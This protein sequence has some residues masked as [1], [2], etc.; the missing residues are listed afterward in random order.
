MY[1]PDGGSNYVCIR[2]YYYYYFF[3][4]EC[5]RNWMI[6]TSIFIHHLCYASWS[7][8]KSYLMF[9]THFCV[10]YSVYSIT[11][12]C[13]VIC[14]WCCSRVPSK[15]NT[16][17][18]SSST[19]NSGCI[20]HTSKTKVLLPKKILLIHLTCLNL[21]CDN[22][23]PPFILL[24]ITCYNLLITLDK[25][26][27]YFFATHTIVSC[28]TAKFPEFRLPCTPKTLGFYAVCHLLSES[29]LAF[30]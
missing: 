21:F 3:F 16:A 28:L 20:F 24:D 11:S 7:M 18:S 8:Y 23:C 6:L 30:Q 5:I 29:L 22:V 25:F 17:C 4:C 13:C 15:S 2:N 12:G 26:P 10:D 27:E 9:Q 14:R 1:I 19:L